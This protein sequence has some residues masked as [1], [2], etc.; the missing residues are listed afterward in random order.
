MPTLL[1]SITTVDLRDW[2][3]LAGAAVGTTGA[4][5]ALI[6]R[7]SKKFRSDV[8]HIV[9]V[10]LVPF[11]HRQDEMAVVLD[12]IVV[13]GDQVNTAVNH[14]RDGDGEPPLVKRVGH[15]EESIDRLCRILEDTPTKEKP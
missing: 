13:T 6:D 7:A 9:D 10:R 3:V 2:F 14:V 5:W 1:S 12:R 8:G 4:V 11:I 15:I